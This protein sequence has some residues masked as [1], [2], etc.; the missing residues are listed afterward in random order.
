M[1][2]QEFDCSRLDQGGRYHPLIRSFAHDDAP[3]TLD[4]FRR[5][6]RET[7]SAHYSGEQILAWAPMEVNEATWHERRAG[8]RTAVAVVDGL[9]VGFT[10]VDDSGYIDMM[11]VDP[12]YGRRGIASALLDWVL[13][14]A[15]LRGAGV[16]TTHSS[17]TARPFFDAH[18]FLVDEVR[19]PEIRGVRMTNFAMS[20]PV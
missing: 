17:I 6:I 11:F 12:N 4:V 1:S 7:A 19:H 3:T 9:V 14:G 2:L 20:R 13:A 16:L 18:G 15:A 8:A 5:S 10:D